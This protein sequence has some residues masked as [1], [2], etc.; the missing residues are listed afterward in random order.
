M[1]KNTGL[2][3]CLGLT[4]FFRARARGMA[5]ALLIAASIRLGLY[6]LAIRNSFNYSS[7]L[8]F[9]SDS[10]QILCILRAKLNGILLK[11]SGG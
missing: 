2:L 3:V 8:S 11:Q 7:L 9:D 4:T 5:L 10:E 6:F 1:T